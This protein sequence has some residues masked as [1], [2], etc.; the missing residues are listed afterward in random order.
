MLGEVVDK[1]V[2]EEGLHGVASAG[3]YL[4]CTGGV[5]GRGR[6][7]IILSSCIHSKNKDLHVSTRRRWRDESWCKH[8]LTNA[9][10]RQNKMLKI[11]KDLTRTQQE[12]KTTGRIKNHSIKFSKDVTHAQFITCWQYLVITHNTYES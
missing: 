3:D 5:S 12:R 11:L 10:C 9:V 4:V 8:L 2:L 7:A 1:L 6:E